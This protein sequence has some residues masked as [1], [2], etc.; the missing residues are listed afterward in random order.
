MFKEIETFYFPEKKGRGWVKT[1]P[2]KNPAKTN[3]KTSSTLITFVVN[4]ILN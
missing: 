1:K 3:N 4:Q 2:R